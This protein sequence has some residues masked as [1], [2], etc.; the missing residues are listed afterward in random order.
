[1]DPISILVVDDTPQN[2]ALMDSL[3]GD[4]YD[5]IVANNGERALK[6]AEYLVAGIRSGK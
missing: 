6:V 1:M 4:E 3:L 2:L 5:T